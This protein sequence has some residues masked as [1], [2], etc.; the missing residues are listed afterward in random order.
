MLILIK[1]YKIPFYQD[2]KSILH[3]KELAVD[4][5]CNS[6]MIYKIS[7]FINSLIIIVI[8][9]LPIFL[10]KVFFKSII[11]PKFNPVTKAFLF[12]IYHHGF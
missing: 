10:S 4:I 3:L 11:S 6:S 2:K 9:F 5:L 12:F 7:Y 8:D 1:R